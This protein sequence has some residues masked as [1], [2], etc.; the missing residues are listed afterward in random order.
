MPSDASRPAVVEVL[1][2]F[3]EGMRSRRWRWYVFGAQA[4]VAYGRPRMTADVD[5]TVDLAG[6]STTELLGVLTQSGFEER[7][8]LTN[9]F[10]IRA[11]LLPMAHSGTGVPVD[12]VIA[13][14]GLQ[15]D[16]LAR[17]RPVDIG[18]LAVPFVSVEDLVA[19]KVLAGRR[20]DLEDVR[21]VLFERWESTDF[22]TI[23]AVLTTLEEALGEAKLKPRL[24]RLMSA[25]QRELAAAPTGSR[26][27]DSNARKRR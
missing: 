23:E 10:L 21:G 7:I 5:V 9:D 17:S 13:Q 16:F 24:R 11:R 14:P 2:S 12:V 3:A 6:A 18:G 20:K 1:S 8:E 15:H 22:P 19:M 27:N 4:V 26:V 25:V